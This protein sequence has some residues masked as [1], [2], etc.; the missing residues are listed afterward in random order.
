MGV[1]AAVPC[2]AIVK[3]QWVGGFRGTGVDFGDTSF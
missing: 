1:W 2:E 3:W